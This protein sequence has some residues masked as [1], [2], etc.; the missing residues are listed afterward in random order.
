MVT[1]N[2]KMIS[3][4]SVLTSNLTCFLLLECARGIE[5]L[6]KM[7][8]SSLYCFAVPQKSS[9]YKRQK[10]RSISFKLMTEWSDLTSR[11]QILQKV[12]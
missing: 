6:Q 4:K 5:I 1:F 7:A 8:V 10:F 9:T 3:I 12:A 11:L 2:V